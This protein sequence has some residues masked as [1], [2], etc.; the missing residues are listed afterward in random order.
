MGIH[1]KAYLANG[2]FSA[3]DR[4]YNIEIARVLRTSFP[5]LELFVPQEQGINDKNSYANS[6]M[7]A[8][9]DAKGLLEADFLVAVLDGVEIDSGVSAEIGIFWTTGRPIF[10]LYTDIRQH[11][12]D[13]NQKIEALIEDP[14]ENQFF[15]RNLMTVGLIKDRGVI[16]SELHQL[17][18]SINEKAVN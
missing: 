12:R 4:M 7:I 18:E 6:Q 1:M 10:G 3:A 2:L 5:E 17:I 13:N 8:T 9:A 16:V 14:T 11:G 15:Y